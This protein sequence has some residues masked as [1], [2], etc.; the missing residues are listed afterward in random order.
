MLL[1][2]VIGYVLFKE[3]DIQFLHSDISKYMEI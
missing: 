1:Q 3:G 2:L